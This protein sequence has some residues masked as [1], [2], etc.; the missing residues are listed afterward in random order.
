MSERV[1]STDDGDLRKRR[2]EPAS[3]EPTG[4]V[5]VSLEKRRG[6][7]VTL[8]HNVPPAEIRDVAAQLKRRCSSG[9]TVKYG[10]IEIQGDHRDTVAAL[11]QLR[12]RR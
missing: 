1:Y 8:V 6:K 12:S 5:R 10:V 11:L 9:G 3:S 4:P 7:P 2:D